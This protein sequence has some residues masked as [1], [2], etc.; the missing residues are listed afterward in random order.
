V[1]D[2][3]CYSCG[4]GQHHQLGTGVT[5]I[6]SVPTIIPTLQDDYCISV[7]SGLWHSVAI[8]S[9]KAK[10]RAEK[11]KSAIASVSSVAESSSSP[12]AAQPDLDADEVD[13]E[14]AELKEKLGGD[15]V[16]DDTPDSDFSQIAATPVSSQP[17]VAAVPNKDSNSPLQS[18]RQVKRPLSGSGEKPSLLSRM[19]VCFIMFLASPP[20]L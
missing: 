6:V 8:T 1:S 14:I 5:D 16:D 10:L 12:S 3:Q 11:E 13:T 19:Y 15:S 17:Q 7:R 9:A 2:G 4:I 18:P 20:R